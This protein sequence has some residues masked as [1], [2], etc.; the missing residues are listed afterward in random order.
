MHDLLISTCASVRA[1]LLATAD[2]FSDDE[3]AFRP[4]ANGYSVAETLLHV[5]NEEGGEVR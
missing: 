4:A 5:A 2:K 1:G 3:L